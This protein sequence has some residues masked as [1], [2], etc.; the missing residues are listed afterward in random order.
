MVV[1]TNFNVQLRPKLNKNTHTK[2]YCISSKIIHFLKTPARGRVIPS[3]NCFL[4]GVLLSYLQ[5]PIDIHSPDPLLVFLPHENTGAL[6]FFQLVPE[7]SPEVSMRSGRG[8]D[9]S[10]IVRK[11]K[12]RNKNKKYSSLK[13]SAWKSFVSVSIPSSLVFCI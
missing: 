12:S 9:W 11:L 1:E 5:N 6:L 13:C 4:L 8:V 3:Q 2:N 10:L 7:H